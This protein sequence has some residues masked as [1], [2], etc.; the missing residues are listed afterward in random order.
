M[1]VQKKLEQSERERLQLQIKIE[2]AEQEAVRAVKSKEQADR[3]RE[4]AVKE[5]AELK[6]QTA[7]LKIQNTELLSALAESRQAQDKR[8]GKTE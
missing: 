7:A 6:G 3:E 4:I 5:S 8:K 1:D 2:Q